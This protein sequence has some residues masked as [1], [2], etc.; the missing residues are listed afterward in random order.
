MRR[1]VACLSLFFLEACGAGPANLI[2]GPPEKI[3]LIAIDPVPVHVSDG[4]HWHEVARIGPG[5]TATVVKC[6][7][8]SGGIYATVRTAS[9]IE[10]FINRGLGRF[11]L[12]RKPSEE[13]GDDT[14]WSCRGVFPHDSD[15]E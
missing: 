12:K 6:W 15:Y 2:P 3:Q 11:R 4:T 10:G 14:V 5:E 13:F 8:T 7:A 9:G 1:A